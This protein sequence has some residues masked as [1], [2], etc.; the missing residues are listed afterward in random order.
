M[1]KWLSATLLVAVIAVTGCGDTK[2]DTKKAGADK[3]AATDTKPAD[4]PK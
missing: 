4:Q 1:K 3:P 2:K